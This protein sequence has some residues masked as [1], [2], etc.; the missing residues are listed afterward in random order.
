MEIKRVL[1]GAVG[2]KMVMKLVLD[3]GAGPGM[4]V[5]G[6]VRAGS[7]LAG[8]GSDGNGTGDGEGAPANDKL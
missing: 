1:E 3:E 8:C 4:V 2:D 5:D 7:W 6:G